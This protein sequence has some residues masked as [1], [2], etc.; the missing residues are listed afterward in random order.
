MSV[1]ESRLEG[2]DPFNLRRAHKY[3]SFYFEQNRNI[4]SQNRGSF[5]KNEPYVYCL[6]LFF[7]IYRDEERRY[8]NRTRM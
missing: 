3:F 5:K 7:L 2:S 1:D 4:S 8:E 6:F